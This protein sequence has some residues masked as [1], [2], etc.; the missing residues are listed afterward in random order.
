[1]SPS[2]P[3]GFLLTCYYSTKPHKVANGLVNWHRSDAAFTTGICKFHRAGGR[4]VERRRCIWKDLEMVQ[5]STTVG[6]CVH[7]E[8]E[9]AETNRT[10]QGS[11]ALE[12]DWAACHFLGDGFRFAPTSSKANWKTQT[13]QSQSELLTHCP[14]NGPKNGTGPGWGGKGGR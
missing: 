11:R 10:S 5:D 3:H 1:M 2:L 9:E 13:M 14:Q 7:A 4:S 6:G 8:E 12:D